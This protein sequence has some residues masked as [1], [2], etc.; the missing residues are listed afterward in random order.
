MKMN[1]K[2][3]NID[4]NLTVKLNTTDS[5]YIM[6]VYKM[7][8]ELYDYGTFDYEGNLTFKDNNT[9]CLSITIHINDSDFETVIDIY[10]SLDNIFSDDPDNFTL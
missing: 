9:I 10:K 8:N 2:T 7:L 3:I 1:E 4:S 6:Y 5:S